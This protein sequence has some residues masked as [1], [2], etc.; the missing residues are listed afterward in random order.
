MSR[1]LAFSE[2]QQKRSPN[3]L[4]DF[5]LTSAKLLPNHFGAI[6]PINIFLGENNSGKSRF[7]RE[8]MRSAELKVV[9]IEKD[10]ASIEEKLNLLEQT[11]SAGRYRFA[12]DVQ[13]VINN[14]YAFRNENYLA[15]LFKIR[16]DGNNLALVINVDNIL[17]RVLSFMV[18]VGESIGEIKL[19]VELL[20]EK[21]SNQ[22]IEEVKNILSDLSQVGRIFLD[23]SSGGILGRKMHHEHTNYGYQAAFSFNGGYL[24]FSKFPWGEANEKEKRNE[25]FNDAFNYINDIIQALQFIEEN[26]SVKL[27]S[28]ESPG[29]RTYI[30]ILRTARTLITN[31]GNRL[32]SANDIF[33]HTTD[34]DLKDTGVNVN[35]GFNLYDAIDTT[36]NARH[37]GRT[38]FKEFEDFLSTTF[39]NGKIVEVVAERV[40]GARGGNIIIAVEGVERDIHDLGDGI[41]SIVMLLYP[42]FI[43]PEKAWFFI[44]EPE[45]HLHPGF[46]RLFIETIS[47][48]KILRDKLLTIFLTTHSN[49]I[50]DFALDDPRHVN[51]FT[52][53]RREGIG[54]KSTYQIQL[55]SQRDIDN[56]N[57]LGVRNSSVFLAN[58]SIWVEGVS[59]RLYFRAYLQAYINHLTNR[60]NDKIT[61]SLLEGL[62]YTFLEYSGGNISHF[63]FTAQSGAFTAQVLENIK[64]LS[65]S[66]RVMLVADLDDGKDTR[67]EARDSQQHSGFQYVVLTVKEVENMLSP[68][69]LVK[70]LKK[71]FRNRNFDLNTII[72]TEYRSRYLG[73]YLQEKY[74]GFPVSFFGGSGTIGS[75]YKR[76]L[77]EAISPY[78]KWEEMSPAAQKFTEKLYQFIMSHNPRLGSN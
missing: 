34:Y 71:L 33:L 45:L 56:L 32:E 54:N 27:S 77:A 5:S 14:A 3:P 41:Q 1:Y 57:V 4:D 65:I 17:G 49:H 24:T 44:E 74:K 8:L 40:V 42:L 61:V 10:F 18:K 76:P 28:V 11:I 38:S 22:L 50:L 26:I 47:A 25:F 6:A 15:N 60:E 9:N 43:A 12:I 72:Q 59:D 36:R 68:Q 70:G 55:S 64:A 19:F 31:E 66:N 35:T 69:L 16:N 53:R 58:C 29:P 2:A 20:F 21:E 78:V 52:F 51:I 37:G 62:H 30:P 75:S 46:Q 7:M 23:I 67:H 63:N 39:F 73:N 13:I 48:N